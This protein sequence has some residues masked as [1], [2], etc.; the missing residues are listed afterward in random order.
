MFA[1]RVTLWARVQ[2]L[3]HLERPVSGNLAGETESPQLAA[4]TRRNDG[5]VEPIERQ[6]ATL[7]SR[8]VFGKADIQFHGSATARKA[9][10]PGLTTT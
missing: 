4:S 10:R 5:Y 7:S 2:A 6:G 8:S 3:I 1:N 9:H